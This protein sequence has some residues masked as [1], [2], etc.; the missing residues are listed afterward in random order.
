MSGRLFLMSDVHGY[1]Q[2]L[3]KILKEIRFQ[4]ADRMVILGDLVAKGPD[5]L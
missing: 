1:F 3:L 2:P 5:S 4:D